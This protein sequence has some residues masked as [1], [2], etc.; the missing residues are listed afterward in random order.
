MTLLECLYLNYSYALPICAGWAEGDQDR[1]SMSGDT[2][3]DFNFD[4]KGMSAHI[5]IFHQVFADGNAFIGHSNSAIYIQKILESWLRRS[6]M[7]QAM[8]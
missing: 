7:A 1:A 3:Q 2:Y 4:A 8:S 5:K 6:A